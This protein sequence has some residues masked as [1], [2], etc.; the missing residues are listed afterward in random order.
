MNWRSF[1]VSVFFFSLFMLLFWQAGTG[2]CQGWS[3][4]TIRLLSDDCFAMVEIAEG[5][6]KI[7]HCPHHDMNGELDEEQ[8]IYVIGTFDGE[9]WLDEKNKMLAERH[10]KKHYNRYITRIKRE[11]L[12][13]TVNLNTAK[14]TELVRLPNIG[15]ILAVKIVEYRN[16]HSR[17]ESIDDIKKVEGIGYG[18][19]NAIRHYIKTD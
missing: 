2:R 11:G 6:A 17:F 8:L 16:T 12:K 9:E 5:G 7:K 1:N 10:L 3:E 19:Y 4:L 15:P 13:E 18:T 14:L